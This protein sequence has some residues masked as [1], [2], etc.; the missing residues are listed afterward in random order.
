[1]A[2]ASTEVSCYRCGYVGPSWKKHNNLICCKLDRPQNS[3]GPKLTDLDQ[4]RA[5]IRSI[6]GRVRVHQEDI[7]VRVLSLRDYDRLM[8]LASE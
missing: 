2:S 6:L 7:G 1:M 5:E 4:V 3:V 8:E